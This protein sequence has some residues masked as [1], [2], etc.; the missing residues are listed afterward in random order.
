M[1]QFINSASIIYKKFKYVYIIYTD[2]LTT[3]WQTDNTG[4]K[5]IS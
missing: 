5:Q 1:Q 3:H 2:K 4:D